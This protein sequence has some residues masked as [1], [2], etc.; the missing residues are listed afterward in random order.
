M[1]NNLLYSGFKARHIVYG[2][3]RRMWLK[4]LIV[5]VIAMLFFLVVA[6]GGYM[7]IEKSYTPLD[8]I[9]MTVITITGVGYGEINGPLS[10][11]GRIWSILVI[12]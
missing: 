1:Q 2:Q 11:G 10:D 6:S 8:A 5:L 3:R 9:Y 4:R 7:V 12:I